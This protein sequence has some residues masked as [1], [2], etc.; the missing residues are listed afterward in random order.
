MSYV[1]LAFRVADCEW[2]YGYE[3]IECYW[4]RENLSSVVREKIQL[5]NSVM[6]DN[7]RL[8]NMPV[9]CIYNCFVFFVFTSFFLFSEELCNRVSIEHRLLEEATLKSAKIA[10]RHLSGWWDYSTWYRFG[11][12]PKIIF[13]HL[14]WLDNRET[15]VVAAF[16]K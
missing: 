15:Q 9:F 3:K 6:L 5:F 10:S 11:G 1:Y 4:K 12:T 8:K 7:H 13:R 2:G 14:I 16:F